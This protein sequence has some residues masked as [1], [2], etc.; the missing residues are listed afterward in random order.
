MGKSTISMAIVNS[1]VKVSEGTDPALRSKNHTPDSNQGHT[2]TGSCFCSTCTTLHCVPTWLMRDT[3]VQICTIFGA[4]LGVGEMSTLET[5]PN[6]WDISSD[7]WKW[8]SSPKLRTG[9]PLP[10][11][12]LSSY[13]EYHGSIST[14]HHSVMILSSPTGTVPGIPDQA[15]LKWHSLPGQACVTTK[16]RNKSGS[17]KIY[18][19]S[20]DAATLIGKRLN[21]WTMPKQV[22]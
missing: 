15:R 8:C 11:T 2:R 13:V 18:H 9:H 5:S 1:C 10:T 19:I 3:L 14:V 4:F 12:N 16:G 20:D 7:T 6:Y 22:V 17:T 21:C